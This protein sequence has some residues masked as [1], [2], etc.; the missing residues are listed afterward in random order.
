MATIKGKSEKEKRCERIF[1]GIQ[2]ILSV[3]MIALFFVDWKAGLCAFFALMWNASKYEKGSASWVVDEYEDCYPEEGLRAMFKSWIWLPIWLV[4]IYQLL[5][6][7]ALQF[8][9]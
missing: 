2:F 4:L 5:L 8:L 1:R 3:A 6:F 7:M 9:S